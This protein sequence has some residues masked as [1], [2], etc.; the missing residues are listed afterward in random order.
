ME[1]I[2]NDN[3]TNINS[4]LINAMLLTDGYKLGHITMYPKGMTKL[5]SNFTPRSNKHFPEANYGAVVFGTHYLVKHYLID[6]FNKTFFNRPKDTVVN[7]YRTLLENFLG[8]DVAKKIGTAHIEALHD[9]GYL[10]ILIKALPEGSRC[11]FGVPML[12]ITNT[13]KDFAWLTNYLETLIST[14]LW[15]P[16][17]SATTSDVFKRELIRHAKKTGFFNPKD[18]SNLDFLCHD[19]SMRGMSG[20]EDSMISG[21]G[22][23]VSF[24]GSETIPAI[25]TAQHYYDAPKNIAGTIPATEHSIECTCAVDEEGIPDDERYFREM[26]YRFPNGNVS[27]V[28]DGFDYWHVITKILPKYKDKIMSRNG[29]VVI[30]PDSG[31]PVKII[32]GDSLAKENAVNI[33]TYEYLCRLFGGKIN[34]KGYLELD[35]HIGLLYGDAINIKRQ[36][37]IYERLEKKGIAA[38]NLVLGIGSYTYQCVSRD[39]L[40]LAMKA[41]YCEVTNEDGTVTCKDIYKDPKTVVGMP[42]KSLRG[43][44]KVEC[45][46][47]RFVAHEQVTKEEETLGI[48]QPIF[49]NGK[50]YNFIPFEGIKQNRKFGLLFEIENEGKL[51]CDDN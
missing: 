12:T 44:I 49:E 37:E 2:N 34:H 6:E 13:H 20:I 8:K 31:D 27:I 25:L 36:K 33:G 19:F 3:S 11:P 46:D 17:N 15:K 18:T 40:G 42:K 38:T 35:S 29:R 30:R 22:H 14:V 32:C 21:M 23:L 50:E 47:G 10:P 41:T 1:N 28:C 48:L 43:L 26:L 45:V 9:L 16:V 39:Q 4:L 7:E 24:S 5:Y 51:K